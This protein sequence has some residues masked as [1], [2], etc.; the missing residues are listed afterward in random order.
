[1]RS[2]TSATL[3]I[4]APS[5][6]IDELRR[7]GGYVSNDVAADPRLVAQRDSCV[8]PAGTGALLQATIGSDAGAC[9]F[10]SCEQAGPARAWT[11]D[12]ERLLRQV[13]AAVAEQRARRLATP[14]A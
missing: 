3:D 5:A 8:A 14:R 11:P 6:W 4:A 2:P 12:D 1:M 10:I 7:G 13:A 9:G